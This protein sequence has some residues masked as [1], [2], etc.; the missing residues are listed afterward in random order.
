[1]SQ[2]TQTH[3]VTYCDKQ[4]SRD[5]EAWAIVISP[6]GEIHAF[7][8]NNIPGLVIVL[9]HDYHK[10]GKWSNT[11][12]RLKVAP[13]ARFISGL[14][15]WET[16]GWTE[17]LASALK[18]KRPDTWQEFATALGVPRDAVRNFLLMWRPKMAERLDK[19]EADLAA[20]PS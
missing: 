18:C 8:G 20:F 15:G 13:G 14:M 7:T 17:G 4:G 10:N 1:M 2:P 16:G 5:R 11:T 12:Y 6:L 9:G 3:E 19:L